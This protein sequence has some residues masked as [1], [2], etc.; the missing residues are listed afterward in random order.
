MLKS[1]QH[2]SLQ[3]RAK[4]FQPSTRSHSVG[5]F[6]MAALKSW[7][8]IPAESHFSIANIPFGIITS[9]SSQVDKRPAVAIG[10]YVLDLKA[11]A[12]G[13]GFSGLSSF[14]DHLAVFSQPTLNAFAALGQP[15]HREVRKYL[16]EVFSNSTSHPQILKDN[17][18]LQ[19]EALLPKHETKTHLPMQIGDYTDFFAGIN[20]AFNVGTMFRVRSLVLNPSPPGIINSISGPGKRSPTKLYPPA[21]GLSRPR[22]HCR[23]FRYANPPA[24]R[25]NPPRPH[26]R[27]QSPLLRA[28]PPPRH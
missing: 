16:Q 14:K 9:R 27:P 6:N 5:S 2:S 24:Q 7:L 8:S 13:N 21:G 20:H 10:D 1:L 4:P 11:F 12:L 19:K 15:V 3:L 23:D 17:A 25:A 26:R 18:V 22:L 28:L